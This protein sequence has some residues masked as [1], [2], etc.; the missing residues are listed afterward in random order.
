LH[1]SE[2]NFL[3]LLP[4]YPML[5]SSQDA[6]NVAAFRQMQV[7]DGTA[8]WKLAQ[9]DAQMTYGRF[10][11]PLGISLDPAKLPIVMH[12]LS[13]MER[14]VLDTAFQAKDYFNRPRPYQRF[15]VTHVCGVSTFRAA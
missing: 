9:S 8:R 6:V 15:S 5:D 12:L 14:D 3:L 1:G 10:A 7:P 13:R 4:P 2:P 11:E